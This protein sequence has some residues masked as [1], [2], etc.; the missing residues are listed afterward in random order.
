M[1]EGAKSAHLK[2]LVPDDMNPRR[3]NPRNIGMIVDSLHEV[4]AARSGVI[5]EDNRILAG[6]GTYEALAEAGI[7]RVKI[8]EADGNEWVVV[9]RRGLTDEQKR[10]LSLFDNRT[11]ETSEWDGNILAQLTAEAPALAK[12][13][14]TEGELAEVLRIVPDFQPAGIEEQGRLDEKAKVKCPECGCEFVPKT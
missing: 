6:N 5:D 9:K 4:G 2:D 14:W 12:G 13:L 10:R 3:H 7:E 8:V 1:S 11:Q